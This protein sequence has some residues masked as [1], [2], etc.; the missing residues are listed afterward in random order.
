LKVAGIIVNLVPYHHARWEAFTQLSGAE[1]HL[2]ELRNHDTFKV[3]EF[4]AKASYQR[5]TLFP[6]DS[7]KTVSASALRRAMAAKLDV[8]RPEVVCVSGWA[9]P[10][11][12]AA[13]EWAAKNR[14]PVVMLSESNEWDE[15]RS[16]WRE[17][18]KRRVVGFSSAGLAGGKPQADY[19]VKLGLSR[20]NIFLGYDVVDNAYFAAGAAKARS[21]EQEAGSQ[22]SLPENYFLACCRFGQKKNLP[23]LL[24]AYARYR[25]L[26]SKP[27]IGNRK[28][29]IWSLV[30]IGDGPLR[31]TLNSQLSTLNLHEHVFL[32]GA[33]SYSEI[34]AC[35][36]LAKTFIHASTTEQ[37]GLVVNEAMASGLPVLVSNRCGCAADLV[38][39]GV[40][41][42][43]F[44]PCNVEQLAR[45]MLRAWSMESAKRAELG[46]KSMEIISDWG[47]ER[48]AHGLKTAAECALKAGPKRA[49]LFDRLLLKVLL[50][51]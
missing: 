45:L 44:D 23:R 36:G 28:P 40:N 18:V 5:Q 47:P 9:L 51:R 38:Q 20:E 27:E 14:V 39:E 48:F 43:T 11:S 10:V 1:C 19:L 16:V 26:A 37:W 12:L 29:E 3:L 8:L 21:E 15:K 13:L 35:Y 22:H 6:G 24:Q 32:P 31:E 33:K 50:R 2:L 30:L 46:A 41:G 17:A 25:E 42:F 7:G 4:S 49:S 34:P